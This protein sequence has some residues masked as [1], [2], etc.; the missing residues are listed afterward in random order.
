MTS[1]GDVLEDLEG[2]YLQALRAE[3]VNTQAA[4]TRS[5]LSHIVCQIVDLSTNLIRGTAEIHNIQ[6]EDMASPIIISGEEEDVPGNITW[7]G[8]ID[9]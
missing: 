5:T 9:L 7:R 1:C 2:H 3:R 4:I 8:L 6:Q